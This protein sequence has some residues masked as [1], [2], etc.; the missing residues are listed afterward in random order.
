LLKLLVYQRHICKFP[1]PPSL[2]L[3]SLRGSRSILFYTFFSD[4]PFRCPLETR[5]LRNRK[6][7]KMRRSFHSYSSVQSLHVYRSQHQWPTS[8]QAIRPCLST[9]T[10]DWWLLRLGSL[11]TGRGT[12]TRF[13]QATK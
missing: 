6:S 10:N 3:T 2:K 11:A 7:C 1:S 9:L 12:I 4:N 13:L 5:I 8:Q